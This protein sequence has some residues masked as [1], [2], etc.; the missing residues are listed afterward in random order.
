M[1]R[2]FLIG[3]LSLS[4]GQNAF[5][6]AVNI[7]QA[8]ADEIAAALSGIGIAKAQKIVEYC[9]QNRCHKAE[10][11]LGVSGIGEKTLQKIELDLMFDEVVEAAN[12]S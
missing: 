3:F 5:A 9:Q 7:N 12:P 6:G 1:K 4:M 2:L 8:S 10:D 11:L